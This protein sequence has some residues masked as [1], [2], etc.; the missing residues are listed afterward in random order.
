MPGGGATQRLPRAIGKFAAM[1]LLLTGQPVATR[2]AL[3]LGLVSEVVA[4][5]DLE[6]RA[7]ALADPLARGPQAAISA[8]KEAVLAGTNRPLQAGLEFERRSF[9]L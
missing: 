5:D 1:R 9:A 4:G 6:A 2:E 3:Q 8:I 7:L